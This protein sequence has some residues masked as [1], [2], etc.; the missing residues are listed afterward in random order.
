MPGFKGTFG[1]SSSGPKQT[2]FVGV[3]QGEESLVLEYKI[4]LLVFM[5][6]G[7]QVG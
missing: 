6:V 4:W 3:R 7:V 2:L 5:S 1:L